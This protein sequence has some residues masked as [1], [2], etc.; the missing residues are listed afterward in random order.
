M[1]SWLTYG[2]GTDN[3]NLPGFV[4]LCPTCRPRSVRRCGAT[5]SCR[6]S[7]RA[8]SSPTRSTRPDGERDGDGE[9]EART[10]P[11]KVVIE[12][13]FDPKKLISYVHNEKFSLTEQR[14]E[15][16]LLQK[17]EKHARGEPARIRSSRP[18]SSRWKS[19]IGCRPRR[20]KCSTSARKRKAT[21]ELYGPGSTRAAA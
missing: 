13:D 16:D 8:R 6:P 9:G 7:T 18:P 3:Q 11:K 20:R 15:L 19:P 14:R 21:L 12:K 10:K 5:H 17:L 1:G 4:V 2:L